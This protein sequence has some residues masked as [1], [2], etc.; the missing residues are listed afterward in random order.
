MLEK[1]GPG[2]HLLL[3]KESGHKHKAKKTL[4]KTAVGGS[5]SFLK[6]SRIPKRPL[7]R[8]SKKRLEKVPRMRRI[9]K[10]MRHG[11]V[12]PGTRATP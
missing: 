7:S 3:Q 4:G 10:T 1:P 9:A 11:G 8:N 5:H 2:G 6:R 12:Q